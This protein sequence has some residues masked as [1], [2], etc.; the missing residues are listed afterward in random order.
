M[1]NEPAMQRSLFGVVMDAC[2]IE[3][4]HGGLAVALLKQS[5]DEL[6]N[7][8]C[9]DNARVRGMDQR[10]LADVE[11]AD[12][13]ALAVAVEF[14]GTGQAAWWSVALN[15]RCGANARFV[16]VGAVAPPGR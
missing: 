7:T 9:L 15:R 8:E 13:R 12:D 5:F 6:D 2:V 16:Q 11:R 14:D 10:I 1:F 3:H 4:D